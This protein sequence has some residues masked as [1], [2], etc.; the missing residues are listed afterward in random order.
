MFDMFLILSLLSGEPALDSLID[1]SL[2][3]V[4]IGDEGFE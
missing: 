2:H 4:C 3:L 1:P